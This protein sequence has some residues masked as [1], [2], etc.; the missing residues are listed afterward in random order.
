M[1]TSRQTIQVTYK[2]RNNEV[3]LGLDYSDIQ[4][5]KMERPHIFTSEGQNVK[6]K[7]NCSSNINAT[8]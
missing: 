1:G 4:F 5:Q 7:P 3:G 2:N 6:L 8:D